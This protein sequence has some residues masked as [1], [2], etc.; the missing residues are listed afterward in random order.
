MK[1][2]YLFLLVGIVLTW[3]SCA[4]DVNFTEPQPPGTKDQT[5]FKRRYQGDYQS[6]ADNSIIT[7]TKSSIGQAWHI[8]VKVHKD[9]LG[10]EFTNEENGGLKE[11]DGFELT[12][13]GDSVHIVGTTNKHIFTISENQAL[14]YYKGYYFLNTRG[15]DGFWTVKMLTLKRGILSFKKFSGTE[16]E[17]K[18]LAELTSAIDT[19]K[20]EEGK[21]L[22]Y[23]FQPTLKEFKEILKSVH[24][25][26][27][28]SFK[29]IK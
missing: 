16:A 21:I 25:N 15:K 5:K 4:P 1:L 14:R 10:L 23:S 7:I 29:K 3:V 22:D 17:I 27:S 18:E 12:L 2:K 19:I 9:S 28:G 13:D 24:F 11:I 6:L 26:D 20:N 8:D